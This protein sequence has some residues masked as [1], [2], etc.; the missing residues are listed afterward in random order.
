MDNSEKTPSFLPP[1]NNTGI[2]NNQG[3]D[4]QAALLSRLYAIPTLPMTKPIKRK[5]TEIHVDVAALKSRRKL[6]TKLNFHGREMENNANN[7][8]ATSGTNAANTVKLP[9]IRTQDATVPGAANGAKS[10]GFKSPGSN[11]KL[12]RSASSVFDVDKPQYSSPLDNL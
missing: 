10:P 5:T 1:V 7:Y 11:R 2:I 12:F 4:I 6:G 8:V 3:N 9:P